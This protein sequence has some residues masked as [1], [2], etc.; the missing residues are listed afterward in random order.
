[1]KAIHVNLNDEWK[2]QLQLHQIPWESFSHRDYYELTECGNNL[3]EFLLRRAKNRHASDVKDIKIKIKQTE[4]NLIF[5]LLM[6]LPFIIHPSNM[7][8][9]VFTNLGTSLILIGFGLLLLVGLVVNGYQRLALQIK[10]KRDKENDFM[11][12]SLADGI[13]Y[14][15]GLG[16]EQRPVKINPLIILSEAWDETFFKNDPVTR[17]SYRQTLTRANTQGT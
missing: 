10:I 17:N 15:S 8:K 14:P 5:F 16:L 12:K 7:A 2:K 11:A 6:S 1:M 9:L 3:A 13:I 4:K